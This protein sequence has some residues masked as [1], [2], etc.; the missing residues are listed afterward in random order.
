MEKNET[1][2]HSGFCVVI[3]EAN[4]ISCTINIVLND[5]YMCSIFET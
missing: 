5:L 1:I 4:P 3:C 2:K